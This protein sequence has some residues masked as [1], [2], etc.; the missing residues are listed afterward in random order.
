MVTAAD[1]AIVYPVDD[2]R[3]YLRA[4][5]AVCLHDM[6][7]L[8]GVGDVGPR[9]RALELVFGG[10]ARRFARDLAA[11][12]WDITE[13][14][15]A[16]ASRALASRYGGHIVGEDGGFGDAEGPTLFVANHPGLTDCLALYATSPRSDVRALARPRPLLLLLS[17]LAPNLL[18]LPDGGPGRGEA[19]RS[20]LRSL[21]GGGALILFAAGQLEPEP[22]LPETGAA[23]LETWSSG[24]GTLI[25]LAARDGLPLHIVPTA[26]SGILSTETWRRFGPLIHRRRTIQ[27]R[28][29]LAAFL[30]LAFPDVGPT[31]VR[32]RYG[33]PLA[34]AELASRLGS[35]A[36]LTARVRAEVL[37]L[38]AGMLSRD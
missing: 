10:R 24:L 29:D 33:T 14:G 6:A 16:E 5:E 9:R 19:L 36:A 2:D 38:L 12:N 11:F 17:A 18:F 4:L 15:I 13:R 30:Q 23:Q 35:P 37:R 7:A 27:G 21:R 3:D 32:V 31:T 20:V 22:L 25:R 28:A 1:D 26:I 34:A 8:A